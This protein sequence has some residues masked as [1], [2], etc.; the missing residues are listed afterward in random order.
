MN[1]YLDTSAL[2]KYFHEEKG[3]ATI[4]KLINSQENEI[5]VLELVRIEFFS[6]L[7]RRFRNKEL[8]EEQ[9]KEAISGFNEAIASFN[10]EPLR[11]AII[12]ESEFLLK[13]YG[14]QQGLRAL[15]ALHL[16]T[17]SL[18]AEKQWSFVAADKNLC[19][20]AQLIGFK[21]VNPL[22]LTN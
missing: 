12:T 6:A 21:A 20:V 15:D 14:R 16:G 4:T 13:K 3:S 7:F 2:V 17:F 8:N 18:I 11:Q 22:N 9:L 10:V 19:D 1:L 5:W